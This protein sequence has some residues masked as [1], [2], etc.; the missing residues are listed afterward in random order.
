MT[1]YGVLSFPQFALALLG[2]YSVLSLVVFI[3]LNVVFK[4]D[5]TGSTV[6]IND[7]NTMSIDE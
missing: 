3:I 4:K 7:N 6:S 1:T 5:T 2:A